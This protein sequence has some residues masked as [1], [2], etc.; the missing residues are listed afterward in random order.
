MPQAPLAQLV[1]QARAAACLQHGLLPFGEDAR[2]LDAL[3]RDAGLLALHAQTETVERGQV[4][5]GDRAPLPDFDFGADAGGF[6]L[7]APAVEFG[8]R[9]GLLFEMRLL[10][11]ELPA[12]PVQRFLEGEPEVGHR[13]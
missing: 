8:Q 11:F 7:G 12:S 2:G 10:Q 4:A 3:L 13:R 9:G 6:V 5:A 1:E